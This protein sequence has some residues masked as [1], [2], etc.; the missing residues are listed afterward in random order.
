MEEAVQAIILGIVQG[1]TEFLPISSSGHLILV[2][3]V[4]GWDPPT[5][6]FDVALHLGTLAAVLLYFRR[7]LVRLALAFLQGLRERRFAGH[8]DRMIALCVAVGT[9]PAAAVGFLTEPYVSR[10]TDHPPVVGVLLLVTAAILFSSHYAQGER[11][12]EHLTLADALAIGAAQ[13]FAILPGVSRS[14]STIGMGLFR[15][16]APAEAARFSFLLAVPIIVGAGLS[17]LPDV[18]G[19]ETGGMG[20]LAIALGVIASGITGILA[21]HYLLRLLSTRTLK[22]FAA[23]CLAAG[24][25]TLLL[26]AVR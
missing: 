20:P 1:A 7:D 6:A 19:G 23:Y 10:L 24:L 9:I 18:A 2:P 16:L 11:R 15:G 25:L 8:P 17:E 12:T 4:L 13:A 5:L 22:P 3:W 21:I 14:G 26:A